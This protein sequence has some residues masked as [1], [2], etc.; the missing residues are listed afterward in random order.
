MRLKRTI[1]RGRANAYVDPSDPFECTDHV[2][3]GER[4][5]SVEHQDERAQT[6]DGG[7]RSGALERCGERTEPGL[8]RNR[9]DE[10]EQEEDAVRCVNSHPLLNR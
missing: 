4:V 8:H 9:V 10:R 1:V 7:G 2:R 5:T 6:G 3:L